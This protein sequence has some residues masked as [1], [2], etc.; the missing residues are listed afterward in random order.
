MY[1]IKYS[2]CIDRVKNSLQNLSFQDIKRTTK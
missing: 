1:I 2:K